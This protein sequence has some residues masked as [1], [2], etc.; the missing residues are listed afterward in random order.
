[1][2]KLAAASAASELEIDMNTVAKTPISGY[3]TTR[4]IDFSQVSVQ[5][6]QFVSYRSQNSSVVSI[7]L[8][9]VPDLIMTPVITSELKKLESKCDHPKH[10]TFPNVKQNQVCKFIGIDNL[11]L[12]QYSEIVKGPKNTPWAVKTP[13]GWTCAGKTNIIADE[14]NPVLKA[15]ICSHGHLDNEFFIKFQEWMQI[16]I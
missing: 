6:K 8:L 12:I 2:S 13:F 10:I 14:Q 11:E 1:M 9:A 15:Q 4:E 7:D 16:E 3:H 5:I